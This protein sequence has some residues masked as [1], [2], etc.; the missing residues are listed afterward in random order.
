MAI[1]CQ[2]CVFKWGTATLQEIQSL[3]VRAAQETIQAS[4]GRDGGSVSWVIV[5]GEL[6]LTG[7]S[8][9]ELEQYKIRSTRV[10]EITVPV[11]ALQR[12]ILWKG[13]AQ[14][15]G[16]NITGRVNGALLFAFRFRLWGAGLE[17]GTLVPI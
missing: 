7:F 14:Y 8:A 1:P 2:G 6:V 5:G 3:D 13:F 9:V 16:S 17:I 12:R 15:A 10:M 4:R 11:S